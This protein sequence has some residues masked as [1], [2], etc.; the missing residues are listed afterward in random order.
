MFER[1]IDWQADIPI[2]LW[3]D[4]LINILLKGLFVRMNCVRK[5]WNLFYAVVVDCNRNNKSC[6]TI[7]II[8]ICKPVAASNQTFDHFDDELIKQCSVCVFIFQVFL[9]TGVTHWSNLTWSCCHHVF[10]I[11]MNSSENI[12]FWYFSI[13]LHMIFFVLCFV[14]AKWTISIENLDCFV[15]FSMPNISAIDPRV[16]DFLFEGH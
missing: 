14:F 16:L 6:F 2:W 7:I 15:L 3:C 5:K 8:I 9:Y 11:E 4:G 10:V 1:L 12:F 13:D